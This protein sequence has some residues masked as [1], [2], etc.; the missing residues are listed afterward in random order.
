[1]LKDVFSILGGFPNNCQILFALDAEC[2]NTDATAKYLRSP[3]LL[4]NTSIVNVRQ[5]RRD[6]ELGST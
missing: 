3:D 5:T 2:S 6:K 4:S 1:M